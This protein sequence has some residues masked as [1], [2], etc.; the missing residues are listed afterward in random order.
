MKKTSKPDRS[1]RTQALDLLSRRDYSRRE[2]S[3]KLARPK[4]GEQHGDLTGADHLLSDDPL[5]DDHEVLVED[6]AAT[7]EVERES[8]LD[9]FEERGWLSDQRFSAAF[10]RSRA[11]RG[12][13]PLRLTQELRQKGVSADE[14]RQALNECEFDWFELALQT[15]QRK[16]RPDS[17]DRKD[18]R[19][20]KAALTRFL[21]YRGFDS[22]QIRYALEA[23][24]AGADDDEF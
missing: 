10:V 19:K 5:L 9:E 2:L 12:L 14:I 13:G 7:A 16:Y 21:M 23:V 4:P 6:A 8:L 11:G 18:P 22:E 3:R 20:Q 1:L 24:T 15:A 17:A